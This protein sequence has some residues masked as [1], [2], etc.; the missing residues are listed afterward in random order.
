MVSALL[1]L[2]ADLRAR[3]NGGTTPFL[4]AVRKGD[5]RTVQAMLAAAA[6]T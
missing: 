3:S 1:E 5:M 4:F 6:P 2:G